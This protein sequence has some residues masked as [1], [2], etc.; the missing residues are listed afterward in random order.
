MI[1]VRP[2]I[3]TDDVAGIAAAHG[4]LTAVGGRTSHAAVVARHLARC[5]W[6][7]VTRCE[8]DLRVAAR[9]SVRHGR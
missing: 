1:L 3:A 9:R 7:A 5:A 4:V 6:S 8:V 2:D